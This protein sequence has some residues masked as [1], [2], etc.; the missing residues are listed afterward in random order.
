MEDFIDKT[1]RVEFACRHALF[2][3]ASFI[4]VGVQFFDKGAHLI[5]VGKNDIAG[6]SEQR[7]VETAEVSDF[8]TYMKFIVRNFHRRSV[9]PFFDVYP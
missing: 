7:F 1:H 8:F 3:F 6:G 4:E 2:V 9:L 5:Q